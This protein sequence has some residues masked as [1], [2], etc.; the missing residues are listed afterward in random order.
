MIAKLK[1]RKKDKQLN[2][3]GKYYIKQGQTGRNRIDS[4]GLSFVRYRR[5]IRLKEYKN[6]A[7]GTGGSLIARFLLLGRLYS[8]IKCLNIAYNIRLFRDIFLKIFVS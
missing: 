1:Q 6:R 3:P 5:R 7:M 4:T 8:H 2:Y